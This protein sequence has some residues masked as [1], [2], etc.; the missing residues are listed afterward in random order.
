MTTRI[1]DLPVGAYAIGEKIALDSDPTGTRQVDVE[2]AIEATLGAIRNLTAGSF[3]VTQNMALDNTTIGTRRITLQQLVNG[4]FEQVRLLPLDGTPADNDHFLIDSVAEGTRSIH[5]D[6]IV[7]AISAI[8]DAQSGLQE[9]G[10]AARLGGALLQNTVVGAPA[11]GFDLTLNGQNLTLNADAALALTALAAAA[12]LTGQT[13][14]TVQALAGA[15]SMT[16][17]TAATVSS[18]AGAASLTGQTDANV[19]AT[20]GSVSIGATAGSVKILEVGGAPAIGD[21]LHA[22]AVDGSVQW[23]KPSYGEL[24]LA[25]GGAGTPFTVVTA[26]TPV[27]VTGMTAGEV[28]GAPTLTAAASTFT[29]GASGAGLYRIGA[30]ISNA[31]GGNDVIHMLV[32]RNAATV[33]KL[34]AVTNIDEAQ[35]MA[36]TGLL[37]LNAGDTVSL[38]VDS[39]VNNRTIN[40]RRANFNL[41]RI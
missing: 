31:A 32:R 22:K 5:W 27:Q 16:G 40:I 4:I 1:K 24:F 21:R 41:T 10:T 9:V 12:T 2:D 18:A 38:A 30:Q 23:V 36:I 29:V 15:A 14:A 25:T 19:T 7:A 33:G 39:D 28:S 34:Y 35:C 8:T 20:T 6:Q 13:N 26:G 17:Q 11:G 37:S 3:D